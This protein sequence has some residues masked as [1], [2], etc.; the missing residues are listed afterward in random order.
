MSY[1]PGC[2]SIDCVSW[3]V[4]PSVQFD[5][6]LLFVKSVHPSYW[7]DLYPSQPAKSPPSLPCSAQIFS[8]WKHLWSPWRR[9]IR[10]TYSFYPSSLISRSL[11]GSSFEIKGY[12]P[13]VLPQTLCS[14]WL[15]LTLISQGVTLRQSSH[16]ASSLSFLGFPSVVSTGIN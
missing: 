1:M 16:F 9:R 14:F 3:L 11:Y 15:G 5:L 12:K 4:K 10:Y 8:S 6:W 7:A 13:M 2:K